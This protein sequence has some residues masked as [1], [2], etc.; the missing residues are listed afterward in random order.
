MASLKPAYGVGVDFNE[1]RVWLARERHPELTFLVAEVDFLKLDEVFDVIILPDILSE[2]WNIQEVLES[3]HKWCHPG[4]RVISNT[5]CR[6]WQPALDLVRSF[7]LARPN[8]NQNWITPEDTLNFYALAGFEVLRNWSEILWPLNT[9]LLACFLNRFLVKIWPFST[10]SLTKFTI[11]RPLSVPDRKTLPTVSVIVPARNEADNIKPIF[12]RTPEMGGGTELVFVEGNSNDS[13]Y[14]AMLEAA[15]LFPSRK[16]KI[17]QQSGKGKGDAVRLGFQEA[18]GDILMIL[19]ADM[20]VAPEDLPFFYEALASGKAE[21]VNGVR[22]VYP[23]EDKAMRFANLV[24]NRF[25]SLAFSF[26]LGQNIK[27]TL[28]GTKVLWRKDL[29]R[30]WAAKKWLGDFDPY[31]DF[32]LIFGAAKLNLKIVDLP[33]RY[34]DRVYGTTK[35]QRWRGGVVLLRMVI[36]AA[37]RLKF[38]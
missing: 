8:S 13:T 16:C 18:T 10:L 9:P 11:A 7:G 38:C 30:F 31:G 28:C 2:V 17:L 35:M 14:E 5:Y 20:T 27:D 32:D 33:I 25:F 4:T 23:M 29:P 1:K 24:A 22:L 6:V 3:L 19:D 26:L 15:K 21:F 12:E 36:F 34:R 37:R